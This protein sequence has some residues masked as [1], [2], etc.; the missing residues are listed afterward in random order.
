[1]GGGQYQPRLPILTMPDQ[2]WQGSPTGPGQD[3][4]APKQDH[5]RVYLH[6]PIVD[7]W[8]GTSEF[9]TFPR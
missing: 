2:T 5:E 3:V 1:M 4:A 7:R 9:I 6:L 8:V